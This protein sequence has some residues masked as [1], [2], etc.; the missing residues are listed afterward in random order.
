[1]IRL[2][3]TADWHL[4]KRL[5][6]QSLLEEQQLFL[7]WLLGC[8]VEKEIDYIL[9]AGDLFDV[10]NPPQDAEQMYY[11]FL[12][13]LGKETNTKIII[14]GGNHDSIGAVNGIRP[15]A[16]AWDVV[17]VG[18]P[19]PEDPSQE[20][21]PLYNRSGEMEAVVAATPFLRE[22][23]FRLPEGFEGDIEQR[24][25]EAHRLHY[26]KLAD[27]CNERF[28]N[29]TQI[30]MGHLFADKSLSS[31]SERQVG[32]LNGLPLDI[33]PESFAYVAL[34]HI[35]K[36]Q[37]PQENRIIYSGSPNMLSFSETEY[38]KRV[39]LLE[40]S[41]SG[42]SSIESVPIPVFR[43]LYDW[44]GTFQEIQEKIDQ[45][46]NPDGLVPWIKI[47]VREEK[48]QG[49][50]Y[51]NL[52]EMIQI[53]Q[54]SWNGSAIILDHSL[55]FT[56]NHPQAGMHQ[57]AVPADSVTPELIFDSTFHRDNFEHIEI[58]KEIFDGLIEEI[59]MNEGGQKG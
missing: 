15:L 10:A 24:L 38:A 54:Q 59:Q 40:A 23:D 42:I 3:H 6:Q 27:H 13:R 9:M 35:H 58:L 16:A 17:L 52:L 7:E 47:N 1:M 31:D 37:S 26:R 4:G 34:G 55:Q 36:P 18:E 32:T 19:F 21:F 56:G 53:A 44:T 25:T 20:C 8:C 33:F 2:L 12:A 11:S 14:T 5:K 45:F 46:E 57:A 49:N 28:P 51:A 43:K 30:G 41:A 39:V 50:E 22:K 48:I 29:A